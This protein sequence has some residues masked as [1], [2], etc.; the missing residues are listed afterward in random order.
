MSNHAK[1]AEHSSRD[2]LFSVHRFDPDYVSP[3][4]SSDERGSILEE[5]PKQE[6]VVDSWG[7][8]NTRDLRQLRNPF[9]PLGPL[10]RQW[11]LQQIDRQA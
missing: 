5:V 8:N 11:H 1:A 6:G 7:K 3:Q 10:G 9:V 4:Y 2:I